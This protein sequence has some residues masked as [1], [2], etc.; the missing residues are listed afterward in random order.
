MNA[1]SQKGLCTSIA[2][3]VYKPALLLNFE[4]NPTI[5]KWVMSQLSPRWA[6]GTV[7]AH[8]SV[9]RAELGDRCVQECTWLT[10]GWLAG[11]AWRGDYWQTN[12]SAGVHHRTLSYSVS[13]WP[14]HQF[15]KG[16]AGSFVEVCA[17]P[18][19]FPELP[20]R[21][22]KHAVGNVSGCHLHAVSW[23]PV[24]TI[25]KELCPKAWTKRPVHANS[26]TERVWGKRS[27]SDRINWG[28]TGL[29]SIQASPVSG[30]F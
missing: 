30:R 27:C 20:A 17:C 29:G 1:K 4:K 19:T 23:T 12:L 15:E 13:R 21:V 8:L 22:K 3:T 26:C 28:H 9:P 6:L 25:N 7:L 18:S 5:K 2:E 10:P 14:A 24:F 11:H 16:N